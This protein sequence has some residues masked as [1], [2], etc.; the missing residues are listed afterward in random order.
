MIPLGILQTSSIW[1]YKLFIKIYILSPT[2]MKNQDPKRWII[3]SQTV[4]HISE[5]SP[6]TEH[7]KLKK[8]QILHHFNCQF[9]IYTSADRK[10]KQRKQNKHWNLVQKRDWRHQMRGPRSYSLCTFPAEP[11]YQNS[12]EPSAHPILIMN[13]Q[14]CSFLYKHAKERLHWLNFW[15]WWLHKKGCWLKIYHSGNHL[16]FMDPLLNI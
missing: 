12:L 14:W 6:Y 2:Y 5:I 9:N 15:Y 11:R 16:N 10:W 13:Q 7:Y 3:K 1:T 4:H 8:N